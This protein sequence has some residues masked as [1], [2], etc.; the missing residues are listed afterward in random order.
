MNKFKKSKKIS[1]AS[2][3]TKSLF[4]LEEKESNISSDENDNESLN[5]NDASQNYF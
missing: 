5:E 1:N 2:E 4:E 3:D